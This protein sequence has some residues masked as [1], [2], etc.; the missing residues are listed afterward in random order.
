VT[1]PLELV[2]MIGAAAAGA[3]IAVLAVGASLVFALPGV[4]VVGVV[5]YTA[6]RRRRG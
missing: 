4:A 5:A 2:A 6:S 1:S 3:L